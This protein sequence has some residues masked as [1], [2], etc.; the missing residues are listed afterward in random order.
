MKTEQIREGGREKKIQR[1]LSSILP[2]REGK[3]KEG[4]ALLSCYPL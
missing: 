3:Q 2:Y 1:R 4:I